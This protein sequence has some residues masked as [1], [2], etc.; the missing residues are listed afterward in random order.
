MWTATLINLQQRACL[1]GGG[2]PQIGEV[3][4]L[5]GGNPPLHIIGSLNNGNG[6]ARCWQKWQNSNMFRLAKQQ[7][8]T[9]IMLFYTFLCHLCMTMT[10]KCLISCIVEDENTKQ[11]LCFSFLEL[12]YTLLEFN[13]RKNC[14]HF[15]NWTRWNK[16]DSVWSSATSL[17]K[18]CFHNCHLC[19]CLSSLMSHMVTPPIM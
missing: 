19:C 1:H 14:Q 7:L 16:C 12:H 18:W 6:D 5:S 2:G 11:R 17:C 8:C 15:M 13:C 3:T 10:W 4:P 9:C